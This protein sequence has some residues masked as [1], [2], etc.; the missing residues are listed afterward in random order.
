MLGD[1][2]IHRGLVDRATWYDSETPRMVW[3]IPYSKPGDEE[4]TSHNQGDLISLGHAQ[5]GYEMLSLIPDQ[6]RNHWQ[7]EKESHKKNGH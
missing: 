3:A 6:L 2:K 7:A 4:G 1:R 5:K